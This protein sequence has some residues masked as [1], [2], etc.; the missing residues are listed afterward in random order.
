[1]TGRARE[2]PAW[3]R[4][5]WERQARGRPARGRPARRGG[6]ERGAVTAETAL[7]LPLLVALTVALL[8]LVTVGL[9]QVRAT[10]AAREAARALARGD[11]ADRA[12]ALARTVAPGA[13]VQVVHDADRVEVRVRLPV[14]PPGGLLG[15][16]PGAEADAT[17]VALVEEP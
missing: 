12:T 1:M 6:D 15:G 16:L 4:P 2:R 3:E 14:S 5:A 9:A 11:P 8:W 7:V 13:T 10:D 17:A